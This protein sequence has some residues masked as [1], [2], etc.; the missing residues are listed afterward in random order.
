MS[1]F[2]RKKN[3]PKGAPAWMVT[4]SDI[5]TLC[6]TF[7]V[8]LYSFSSI[9]TH[10]WTKVQLSLQDALLGDTGAGDNLLEGANGLQGDAEIE[11]KYKEFIQYSNE[12]KK[13][14]DVK[15]QLESYLQGQSMS[16]NISVNM[17]ERGLVLRF[18]DSVLFK[19][20]KAD[21]LQESNIIL[22]NVSN[23]FK[24]IDNPIR[25]EGHTDDLPIHTA[26]YPSNWELSTSRATNVL[27][28]IMEQGISGDRL[29]AVGYSKYHPIVENNNEKNRRKNRRVDIVIIRE[30]LQ[31]KEPK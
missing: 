13:L 29:S 18:Q 17:E 23:I 28:Y 3:A 4:Y 21:I 30:S 22:K 10:K 12:M 2:S 11:E 27:R 6:L 24:K 14:E 31:S 19:K 15:Q 20:G 25:V 5:V 16:D 1:R 8:L 7:F 9:D 26:K